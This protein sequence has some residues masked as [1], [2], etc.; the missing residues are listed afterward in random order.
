METC[1]LK[2]SA[3]LYSRTNMTRDPQ[4]MIFLRGRL[5]LAFGD[6]KLSVLMSSGSPVKITIAAASLYH[7]YVKRR[8][9]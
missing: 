4:Y 2:T 6:H 7:K 5:L 9:V 8:V 3:F 1:P